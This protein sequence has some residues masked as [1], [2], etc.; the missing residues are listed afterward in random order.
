NRYEDEV[1]KAEPFDVVFDCI[2]WRDEWK[3]AGRTGAL[4]SG[5]NGGRYI[6]VAATND[7]Q[8]HTVW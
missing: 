3:E 4:K 7:P 2:G 8:I 5:W 1:L 6:V